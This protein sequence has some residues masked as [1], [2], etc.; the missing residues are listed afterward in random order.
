MTM[1][2]SEVEPGINSG[3]FPGRDLSGIR[4]ESFIIPILEE[5]R[6]YP[7]PILR[8]LTDRIERKNI[9]EDT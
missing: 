6:E 3:N 4:L 8:D 9:F 5:I 1:P 7:T 2:G